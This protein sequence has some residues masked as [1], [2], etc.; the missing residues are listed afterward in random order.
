[1]TALLAVL[2]GLLAVALAVLAIRL[3]GERAAHE[4]TRA[5]RRHSEAARAQLRDELGRAQ[6]VHQA[7]LATHTQLRREYDDALSRCAVP[8]SGRERLRALLGS[9]AAVPSVPDTRAGDSD[10]DRLTAVPQGLA[11][12]PRITRGGLGRV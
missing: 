12:G 5:N 9:S 11:A 8:G 3:G 6:Q 7:L 1:M 2:C 10:G 4:R